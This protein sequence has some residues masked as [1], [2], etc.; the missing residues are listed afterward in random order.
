M[1]S[2][3]SKYNITMT[4]G[5]TFARTLTLTKDGET[6]TPDEDDVIRFAMAK[7]YKGKDDYELI[8]SKVIDN[9]T[10]L[11]QIDAEDTAELDYGKYKYDLQITYAD[12]TV[13]TFADKKTITLTEEVE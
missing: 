9:E 5:D 7:V 12:G 2:I 4:R 6:Y 3:D 13:E 8:L 10:L 11:W 1:I